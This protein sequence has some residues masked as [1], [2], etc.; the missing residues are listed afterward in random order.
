MRR[1]PVGK[2]IPVEKPEMQVARRQQAKLGLAAV[3]TQPEGMP[4]VHS[5]PMPRVAITQS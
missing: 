2:I 1:G 4:Q 3:S 5:G